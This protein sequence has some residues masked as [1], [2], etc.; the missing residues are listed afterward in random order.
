MLTDKE[1]PLIKA[2][3]SPE[4]MSTY[5]KAV[6][7]R[8]ELDA[9][10][11]LYDWNARIA[12]AFLFPQQICEIT[13]RNAAATTLEQVFG[14]YWPWSAGF[15]RS[16]PDPQMA[17]SMRKDLIHIRDKIENRKTGD[18]IAE[19]ALKFWVNLF[20]A[21]FERRL[22]DR[23]LQSTF[24]N[25]PSNLNSTKARQLIHDDL[26]QIR[27]LR[28]RIAHHEPI[29]SRNL[30][31]DYERARNLIAWKC[32]ATATWVDSQEAVTSTLLTRP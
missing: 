12:A 1:I 22:W 10:L 13:T 21:R 8:R 20:T 25:L 17:Y 11:K 28:N 7:G 3:L 23:H 26:D 5:E 9:A 16:L 6:A 15:V 19:L 29:F 32:Q 27:K 30:Q 2:A 24:P 31:D 18:V 4:R 14:A